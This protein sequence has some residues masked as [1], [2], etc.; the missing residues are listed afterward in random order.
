MSKNR[1]KK[2]LS[3][4]SDPLPICGWCGKSI[5]SGEESDNLYEPDAAY[6]NHIPTAMARV[7]KAHVPEEDH[8]LYDQMPH[9]VF[10]GLPDALDD[11]R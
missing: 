10:T 6:S 8:P 3:Q 1:R 7:H 5:Q 11:A 2:H 9:I 4:P